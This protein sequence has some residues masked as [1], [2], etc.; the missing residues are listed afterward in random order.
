MPLGVALSLEGFLL[1]DGR[2]LYLRMDDGGGW[3][4]E[5]GR[6]ARKLLGRRVRVEGTRDGFDLVVAK[7]VK[8]VARS[9]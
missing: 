2:H 6:S 5:A 9:G 1:D 3:R 4:I 8:P 7:R